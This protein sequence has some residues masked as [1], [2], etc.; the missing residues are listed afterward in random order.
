MGG[1]VG[2]VIWGGIFQSEVVKFSKQY[3]WGELDGGMVGDSLRGLLEDDAGFTFFA[4]LHGFGCSGLLVHRLRLYCH[5]CSV[6]ALPFS[7][8]RQDTLVCYYE[9][10]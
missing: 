7:L 9:H 8:G 5:T 10:V 2:G 6:E 1:M 4:P 3:V